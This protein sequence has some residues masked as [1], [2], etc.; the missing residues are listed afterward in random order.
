ML[1]RYKKTLEYRY[2]VVQWKEGDEEFVPDPGENWMQ[3]V[4]LPSAIG[5]LLRVNV[6]VV[7]LYY[8]SNHHI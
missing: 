7:I 1:M 6:G 3:K 8:N 2:K 5:K 4:T